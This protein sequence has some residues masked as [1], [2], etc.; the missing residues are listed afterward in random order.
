MRA[1]H[2]VPEG[3]NWDE[4]YLTCS[5]NLTERSV[6]FRLGDDFR[7]NRPHQHHHAGDPVDPL[8]GLLDM[9]PKG[10]ETFF[11]R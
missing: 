10:V 7:A 3:E 6:T 8:W 1:L 2:R 11:P 9:T 5:R 4:P